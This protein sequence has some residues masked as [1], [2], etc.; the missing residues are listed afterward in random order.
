M[1]VLDS[2]CNCPNEQ[3]KATIA[4]YD[5]VLEVTQYHFYNTLLVEAATS[6]AWNQNKGN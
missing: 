2:S 3:N 6:P 4:F 5:P 1:A